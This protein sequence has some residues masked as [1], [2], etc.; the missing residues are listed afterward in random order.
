MRKNTSHIFAILLAVLV[1]SFF[2]A[3]D[4]PYEDGPTISFLGREA[5]LAKT[6]KMYMFMRNDYDY[7]D[8]YDLYELKLEPGGANKEGGS[9]SWSHST[10]S[11]TT[12][13]T[14]TGKWFLT[15]KDRQVQLKFDGG[16][17]GSGWINEETLYL[18]IDRLYSS[19]MWARFQVKSDYYD[20]R[21]KP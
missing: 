11:D 19:E 15:S 5:R 9:F 14:I 2:S 10:V 20:V 13:S 21:F 3:C 1:A 4:R 12:T 18:D 16:I 6:W 7:T 17:L 8:T